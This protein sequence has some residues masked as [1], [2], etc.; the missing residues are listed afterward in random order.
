[1]ED[2]LANLYQAQGYRWKR[3]NQH[4]PSLFNPALCATDIAL[5][6]II[7][8]LKRSGT[9]RLFL[10]GPSG[11]GKSA[12]AAHLA[13]TLKRPLIA[14]KAAK[15]LSPHAGSRKQSLATAFAKDKAR[16]SI[17]L[18][19]EVDRFLASHTGAAHHW[20]VSQLNELLVK[21]EQ[22]PGI[23]VMTTQF[24]DHLNAAALRRFDLK[25]GFGYFNTEQAWMYFN[26]ILG[27]QLQGEFRK[28]EAAHLYPALSRLARLTPGDFTTVLRRHRVMGE[29]L[30]PESLL[31]GLKQEHKLKTREQFCPS[32]CWPPVNETCRTDRANCMSSS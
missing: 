2:I 16:E 18:I 4:Q 29:H 8:G 9:G 1:M 3:L 23:L 10:Y 12:L 27:Q 25:I 20:K 15:L 30:A 7:R 19:D 31:A 6:P 13:D 17:L 5:E 24:M 22:Y 11:T 21:M 14:A 28:Q 26:R 32:V